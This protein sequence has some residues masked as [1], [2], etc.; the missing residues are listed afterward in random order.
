LDLASVST[1]NFAVAQPGSL[2]QCPQRLPERA[3][4]FTVKGDEPD[5]KLYEMVKQLR[6]R[7][8][9][10]DIITNRFPVTIDVNTA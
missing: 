6:A 8:A 2:F 1:D 10:F 5:E 9:V 4:Q 7:S 3:V